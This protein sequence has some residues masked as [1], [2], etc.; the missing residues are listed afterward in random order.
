[1]TVPRVINAALY[2]NPAAGEDLT[3]QALW[4]AASYTRILRPY[5]Y[6]VFDEHKRL[7]KGASTVAKAM[8]K[9]AGLV[10]K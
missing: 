3:K 10:K 8:E 9:K 2:R 4:F 1:M 7:Q 6:N 5:A